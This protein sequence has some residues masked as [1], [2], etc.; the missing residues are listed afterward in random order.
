MDGLG[1]FH[2][3]REKLG[4]RSIFPFQLFIFLPTKKSY[5]SFLS[6]NSPMTKDMAEKLDQLLAAGAEIAIS[7]KQRLT[8][9]RTLKIKKDDPIYKAPSPVKPSS[10]ATTTSKP[11]AP[12]SKSLQQLNQADKA[13]VASNLAHHQFMPLIEKARKEI[14]NFSLT[15]S[16]MNSLAV[17]LSN[18]FLV[19]ESKLTRTLVLAYF[20]ARTM[21]ISNEEK[22][23]SIICGS[24]FSQIGMIS[25][26][27]RMSRIEIDQYDQEDLDNFHK[28]PSLSLHLCRK[29]NLE[30]TED[31]QRI[32]L[33]HQE[34][35]SG[36]GFPSNKNANDI[37][38]PS[39]IVGLATYIVEQNDKE[40]SLLEFL[41]EHEADLRLEFGDEI[42]NNFVEM[43]NTKSFSQA[44]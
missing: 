38:T 27:L 5:S 21:N 13:E 12:V 19:S 29:A 22:L 3:P 35:L 42:V 10:V 7:E 2:I 11:A 23:S 39:L 8:F 43:L 25:M 4:K 44:A 33:D 34:K 16:Q 40:L 31:F 6:A 15:T 9:Q 36:N 1:Y 18:K 24:F 17:Y 32:I 20:L 14:D 37:S 41:K 26:S 28:Y 30:M